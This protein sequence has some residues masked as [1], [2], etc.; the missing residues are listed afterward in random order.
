M[1]LAEYWHVG[2]AEKGGELLRARP[3]VAWGEDWPDVPAVIRGGDSGGLVGLVEV[4]SRRLSGD[5]RISV[6]RRII[7]KSLEK[8]EPGASG[9]YGWHLMNRR[10]HS[11]RRQ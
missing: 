10:S 11:G 8:C 3:A 1:G 2:V 5:P 6:T 4:F 7:Q 9:G